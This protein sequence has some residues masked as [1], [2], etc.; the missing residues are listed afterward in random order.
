MFYKSHEMCIRDRKIGLFLNILIQSSSMLLVKYKHELFSAV[1]LV[2]RTS[3]VCNVIWQSFSFLDTYFFISWYKA[4]FRSKYYICCLHVWVVCKIISELRLLLSW[5]LLQ[6]YTPFCF[7]VFSSLSSSWMFSLSV[8]IVI[9][10]TSTVLCFSYL[11][12]HR[13][14][15]PG[16]VIV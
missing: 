13:L 15:N 7:F 8:S 2:C 5:F 6:F 9:R 14:R 12:P 4:L 3:D 16:F 10:W 1:L 11:F